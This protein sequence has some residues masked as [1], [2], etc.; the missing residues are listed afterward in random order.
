MNKIA[1]IVAGGSGQRMSSIVPKQ[2]LLL[3]QKALLWHTANSFLNAFPDMQLIVV[4]PEA[5]LERGKEVLRDLDTK[6]IIYTIGGNTRFHSV[7]NG[8]KLI[9]E[10]AV[11]FVHDAVR[12]LVSEDLIQRCYFQASDYGSAIPTVIA[13]DSIRFG[14]KEDSTA[15]DRQKVHI[16]QTPQTFQSNVLLPAFE[17]DYEEGFTDEASVVEKNGG[18]VLLIEGEYNN[19][20]ITRPVDLLIAGQILEP[21]AD[22]DA[23]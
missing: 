10:P 17:Q 11:I 16:V 22:G 18:K 19:L 1:V 8:L 15:L 14:T 7:K 12:C 9:K 23:V 3:K 20:K 5:H 6:R 2:F 4:L 21:P 13:T